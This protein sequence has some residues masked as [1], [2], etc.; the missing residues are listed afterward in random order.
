M[1]NRLQTLLEGIEDPALKRLVLDRL[2]DNDFRRVFSRAP[3][4]KTIHHAFLG[5]L[6]EHSLSVMELASRVADQYSDLDRDLLLAGAFLHDVGKVRELGCDAAFEYTD[7]G[8]LLGHI[9]MGAMMIG[10]WAKGYPELSEETLLKLTHMILSH[11]GSYEF[12]S[13]KRPKFIEALILHY[14]DELDSKVQTFKEIAGRDQG[15]RWSA[16]Q[17]VFDR[18]LFL[19]NKDTVE[20]DR[21]KA[22]GKVTMDPGGPSGDE[23][24]RHRALAEQ[25]EPARQNTSGQAR[26]KNG[27]QMTLVRDKSET[28]QEN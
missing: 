17:R 3:A 9:V 23:P 18:Y 22:P 5:G 12:G 7:E 21:D 20:V 2:Q 19:G 11:H 15:N 27:K 8:R 26:D 4:A 16:F 14:L 28:G 25:L 24:L 13:P 10:Q 1:L 6:L